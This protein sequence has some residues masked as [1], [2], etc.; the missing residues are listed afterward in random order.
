MQIHHHQLHL[1]VEVE[2]KDVKAL[3]LLMITEET[4]EVLK[5]ISSWVAFLKH[6][7][8]SFPLK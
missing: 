7:N 8:H 2:P 6:M 1:T 5:I 3:F 4:L